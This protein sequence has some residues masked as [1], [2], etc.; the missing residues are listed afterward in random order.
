MKL[1]TWQLA[2][3]EDAHISMNVLTITKIKLKMKMVAETL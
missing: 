1:P 2:S 3:N